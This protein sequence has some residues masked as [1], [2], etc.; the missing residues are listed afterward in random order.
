MRGQNPVVHGRPV[1]EVHFH[2]VGAVDSIIDIVSTALAINALNI[3]KVFCSRVPLGKGKTNSMHGIIPVPAPATLSILEG[4]P[5]Y[6]G[7]YD[8]E[9]TT[10]TGAAIIRAFTSKFCDFPDMEVEAVGHGAGSNSN[11]A[12]KKPPNILRF[13]LGKISLRE[14]Y[15][16]PEKK[17]ILLGPALK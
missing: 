1:E 9:V 14:K 12:K 5:V 15:S 17:N 8:F 2:E 10:P 16:Q 13:I 4:I 7:G 11:S 6:G 3:E